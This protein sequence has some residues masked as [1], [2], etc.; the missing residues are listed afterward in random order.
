MLV[1]ICIGI[2]CFFKQQWLILYILVPQFLYG[3]YY[4]VAV[5]PAS[6]YVGSSLFKYNM[7]LLHTL[8]GSK[9]LFYICLAMVAHHA[10]YSE[11]ALTCCVSLLL[12]S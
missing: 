4:G 6:I 9:V 8:Y 5:V 7:H 3:R 10:V 12:F 11:T 1:K 2:S